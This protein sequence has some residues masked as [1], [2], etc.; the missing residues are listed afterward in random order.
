MVQA[1]A[2][3]G[4]FLHMAFAEFMQRT[5]SY[6]NDQTIGNSKLYKDCNGTKLEIV[7]LNVLHELCVNT[8]FKKEDI[9]LVSG[10]T[11]PDIETRPYFGI[12][13]KTTE[14]NS[15]VSTGSSIVESTRNEY[16]KR[17][18]ML[19]GKLGGERARIQMSSL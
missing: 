17:V 11:F 18:Y 3:E 2:M 5:E 13:V 8:P 9:V 14:K 6:L 19:F 12:E 1:S 16:I 7:A 10:H 4:G 15:W